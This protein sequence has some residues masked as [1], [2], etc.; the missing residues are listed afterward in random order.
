VLKSLSSRREKSFVVHSIPGIETVLVAD[1]CIE[2][3]SW[4]MFGTFLYESRSD[5]GFRPGFIFLAN[6]DNEETNLKK[7]KKK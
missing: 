3:H 1:E 5:S 2:S 6:S 4:E 7:G